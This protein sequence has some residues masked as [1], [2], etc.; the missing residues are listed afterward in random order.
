MPA[1]TVRRLIRELKKMPQ[2]M[3]VGIAHHDNSEGEIAGWIQYVGVVEE[4]EFY[5][6]GYSTKTTGRKVVCLRC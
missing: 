4:L 3:S 2:N 6:Q 5:N 1:M